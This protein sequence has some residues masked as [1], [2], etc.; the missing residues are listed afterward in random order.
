MDSFK[1]GWKGVA[2]A[3]LKPALNN[4]NIWEECSQV[5]T[6]CQR[7][8]QMCTHIIHRQTAH[9]HF[10]QANNGE[11]G[12]DFEVYRIFIE[13]RAFLSIASSNVVHVQYSKASNITYFNIT[14]PA[15]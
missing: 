2:A 3:E 7:I 9:K 1:D 8:I 4:L 15:S 11:E 6:R 14:S 12:G 13:H 5:G 10:N